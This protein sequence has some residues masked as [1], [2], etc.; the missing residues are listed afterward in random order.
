LHHE[1]GGK[2]DFNFNATGGT[3]REHEQGMLTIILGALHLRLVTKQRPIFNGE[4]AKGCPPAD[5]NLGVLV[6]A[7]QGRKRANSAA[8]P[9]SSGFFL[10]CASLKWLI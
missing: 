3:T 1:K 8:S 9:A 2:K 10:F 6:Q 4:I 5:T 7:S